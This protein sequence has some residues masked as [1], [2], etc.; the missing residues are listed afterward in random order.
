MLCC[1]LF[2][3]VNVAVGKPAQQHTDLTYEEFDWTAD[4]A[5]DGCLNRT[6]PDSSQCCSASL[7]QDPDVQ[8]DNFWR[9]DLT[10]QYEVKTI[11]IFRRGGMYLLSILW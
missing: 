7:I 2:T 9:V 6:Y 1:F 4:K 3:V 11:V 5:V 10:R 8:A